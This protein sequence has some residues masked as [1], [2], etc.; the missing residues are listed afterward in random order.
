MTQSEFI[1]HFILA[2]CVCVGDDDIQWKPSDSLIAKLM[3]DG[4]HVYRTMHS[5]VNAGILTDQ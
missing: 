2:R 4:Q 3:V 5:R 1:H